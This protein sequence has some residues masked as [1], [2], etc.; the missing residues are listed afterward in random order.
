ME[1]PTAVSEA[2]DHITDVEP[3]PELH[4]L[5]RHLDRLGYQVVFN[6]HTGHLVIHATLPGEWGEPHD[7]LATF[8]LE[9]VA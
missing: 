2:W 3:T 1:H 9:Q 8:D 6:E 5:M 4:N 7:L